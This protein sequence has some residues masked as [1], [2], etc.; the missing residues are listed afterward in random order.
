[1]AKWDRRLNPPPIRRNSRLARMGSRAACCER[2]LMHYIETGQSVRELA[3]FYG[4]SKST[5]GRYI[6]DYAQE[7]VSY[8]LYEEA[9]RVANRHLKSGADDFGEYGSLD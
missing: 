5:I 9:R 8:S 4:C 6:R 1:M 2:I 3:A 7:D